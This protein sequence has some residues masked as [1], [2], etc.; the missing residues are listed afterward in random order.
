MTNMPLPPD[1]QSMGTSLL[2]EA[3]VMASTE[4]GMLIA[5]DAPDAELKNAQS[6][7][8][9]ITQQLNRRIAW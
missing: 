2:I 6:K 9:Q 7:I 4:R 5:D 3:L 8:D 1:Y